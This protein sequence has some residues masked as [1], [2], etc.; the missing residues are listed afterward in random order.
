M[1]RAKTIPEHNFESAC[2]PEMSAR[3]RN[4]R[5]Q[6]CDLR[7]IQRS[8]GRRLALASADAPRRA[9]ALASRS[10]PPQTS[11]LSAD[12]D[13]GARVRRAVAARVEHRGLLGDRVHP[14]PT[15]RRVRQL[16]AVP[17]GPMPL[18]EVV[19]EDPDPAPAASP[20]DQQPL[21]LRVDHLQSPEDFCA[22][23][24]A[25]EVQGSD[26]AVH[27]RGRV[28]AV[29]PQRLP[30]GREQL[31][32]AVVDDGHSLGQHGPSQRVVDARRVAAANL[33]EAQ[34]VMV[35]HEVPEIVDVGVRRGELLLHALAKECEIE[36]RIGE[37]FATEARQGRVVE[38]EVEHAGQGRSARR[39]VLLEACVI[40]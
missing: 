3:P 17:H 20:E 4:R 10:G 40:G 36:G 2:G 31:L 19:H 14:D 11:P 1:A 37:P 26:E 6:D 25:D 21:V 27:L 35:V 30:H 34:R 24:L 18:P 38:G 7:R 29:V 39:Q 16:A 13:L 22:E 9:F 23:L 33:S 28:V 32:R 5:E 15:V 8:V 12:K